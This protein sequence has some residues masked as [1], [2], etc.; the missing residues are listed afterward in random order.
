MLRLSPDVIAAG[1]SPAGL[2]MS[3]INR[4]TRREKQHQAL[5][6]PCSLTLAEALEQLGQ[7]L[8]QPQWQGAAG[9]RLVLSNHWLRFAVVPWSEQLSSP[10]ERQALAQGLIEELYAEKASRFVI[11]I[12]ESG[13][14][15]PGLAAALPQ[16]E[17]Q[18]LQALVQQHGLA[19]Q[20]LRPL[21][22]E[23]FA[24]QPRK[25]RG[26]D[27]ALGPRSVTLSLEQMQ[28][29]LS[30]RFPRRYPV[31]GLAELNLQTPRLSLR[32]ERNRIN[33]V[34]AVEASSTNAVAANRLHPPEQRKLARSLIIKLPT[35]H[36]LP[37]DTLECL[38]KFFR[39][40]PLPG[41]GDEAL[42]TIRRVYRRDQLHCIAV[43]NSTGSRDHVR[44][45]FDSSSLP[46]E[47]GDRVQKKRQVR[48][49]S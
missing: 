45:N 15:R 43:G 1:L 17:L 37:A 14:G 33:A 23:A 2:V 9:L 22:M 4:L 44:R 39:V 38:G 19:L 20:S 3:R 7:Q 6:F 10:S 35:L 31:A 47:S 12:S 32:P 46:I 49:T 28:E 34:M 26:N 18:Q 24:Q 27:G 16:A 30:T 40:V 25:L 13:Y 21:L 48:G 11:R 5:Q 8:A 42:G 29:R 36:F 41:S